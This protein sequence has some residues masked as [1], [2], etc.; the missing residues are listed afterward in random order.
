M[1]V[2]VLQFKNKRKK[3]RRLINHIQCTCK[4]SGSCINRFPRNRPPYWLNWC[5]VFTLRIITFAIFD[6]DSAKINQHFIYVQ[7][8]RYRLHIENSSYDIVYA[9]WTD[10]QTVANQYVPSIFS[11]FMYIYWE[12]EFTDSAYQ[13]FTTPKF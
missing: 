4:F 2:L 5:P 10:R 11:T 3:S 6:A 1:L 13:Y 9:K 7:N 12:I 8:I